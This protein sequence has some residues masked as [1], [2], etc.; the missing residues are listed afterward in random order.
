MMTYNSCPSGRIIFPRITPPSVAVIS[1]RAPS[2][3]L[4][5]ASVAMTISLTFKSVPEFSEEGS[6]NFSWS[7]KVG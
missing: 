6:G 2:T 4:P 1:E 7:I 5:S 3:S